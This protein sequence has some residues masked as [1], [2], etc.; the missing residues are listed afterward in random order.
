MLLN[1]AIMFHFIVL[2][3]FLALVM[4]IENKTLCKYSN[5]LWGKKNSLLLLETIKTS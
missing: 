2:N 5:A 4:K 1:V 3:Q